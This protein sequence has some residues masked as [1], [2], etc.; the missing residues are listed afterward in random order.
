M[1]NKKNRNFS[2]K[3]KKE[4]LLRFE[5]EQ[6]KLFY[7]V[8]NDDLY[9]SLMNKISKNKFFKKSLIKKNSFYIDLL[10]KK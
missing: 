3:L 2:E 10:K 7:M 1:G 4:N 6:D 9:K 5:N 8:K